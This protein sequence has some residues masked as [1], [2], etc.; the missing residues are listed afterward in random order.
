MKS[1]FVQRVGGC[2]V[3]FKLFTKQPNGKHAPVDYGT[4]SLGTGGKVNVNV[5]GENLSFASPVEAIA[6]A[7]EEGF[8]VVGG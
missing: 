4:G 8:A 5:G 7:T 6:R 1:L 2:G 3:N